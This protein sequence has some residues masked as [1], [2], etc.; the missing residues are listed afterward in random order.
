MIKR[1]FVIGV[2]SIALAAS[3]VVAEEQPEWKAN[4]DA[5]VSAS[6]AGYQKYLQSCKDNDQFT[7]VLACLEGNGAEKS[8][9]RSSILKAGRY[10]VNK[11]MAK[12]KPAQ[13][14]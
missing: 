11:Y 8:R 10:S 9:A 7:A 13:C 6:S 1:V 4:C 3:A 5:C 2:L 14:K 12:K